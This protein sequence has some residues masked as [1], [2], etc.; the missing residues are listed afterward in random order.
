MFPSSIESWSDLL[1][2]AAVALG[3]LA[4]FTAIIA[5]GFSQKSGKL[6]DEALGK[7]KAEPENAL[8][9]WKMRRHKRV[10]NS[11]K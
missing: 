8:Q 4:A 5:R 11:Q 9:N 7:F 1:G 6:K 2:A 10:W 3:G